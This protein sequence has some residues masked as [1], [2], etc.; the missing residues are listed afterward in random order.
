[1]GV[2]LTLESSGVLDHASGTL[3]H[4]GGGT[5]T[6]AILVGGN[7]TLAAQTFSMTG[8][9]L[10]GAGVLTVADGATADL[11]AG[12]LP[13]GRA[14]DGVAARGGGVRY[15]NDGLTRKTGSGLWQMTG[16]D[17]E[18][19]NSG[20]FD[21][22][23]GVL[24][25]ENGRVAST[26]VFSGVG[27]LR[28][29][30]TTLFENAGAVAPGPEGAVGVLAVSDG[31]PLGAEGQ[32]VIELGGLAPGDEHDQLAVLGE[33]VVDG[34]L[35]VRLVDGFVPALGDQF[36][37]VPYETRTGTFAACDG[38]DLGGGLSLVPEYT[39]SGL[40]LAVEDEDVNQPPMA[41]DDAAETDEGVP[42]LVDVLANDS[43][44]DGDPLQLTAVGSPKSGTAEAAE[45]QVL[46]TPAPGFSGTDRFMYEIGDGRGGTNTAQVTVTVNPEVNQPPQAN[47][48]AAETDEG[49]P[50]LIDVLANDSDPDGDPLQLTAVG[51]PENGTAEAV[52]GQVLYTPA[53]G[54]SGTDAFSYEIGD[55]RGGVGTAQVSVT[56][57]P[58][59]VV[60]VTV[61]DDVTV[62]GGA[63]VE[64][65]VAGFTPTT[66]E[67]RFRPGGATAYDAAPLTPEGEGYRAA[68]PAVTLRGIDYYVF[69]S[70][71]E[72]TV[73]VP[74]EDPENEPIH[75]QVA[76][77]IVTTPAPPPPDGTYR[78]VSVPVDLD[79]P[80]PAAAFEDDY[81]PYDPA[82]WRLLRWEP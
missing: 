18:I 30:A 14:A 42:V 21:V 58:R 17:F 43:D 15:V 26:G 9:S 70:D 65:F 32:L 51:A 62:G 49:V 78:M 82:D 64:V 57:N 60:E 19:E 23:E 56:V 71:G 38:C 8:F 50:V 68:I 16:T 22:A 28:V 40:V 67:V 77:G 46:Y 53:S 41:N 79:D 75:L 66:A 76:V 29:A 7:L 74:A 4:T 37:I 13:V 31:F 73:T 11:V 36:L 47:G 3:R 25:L 10:S 80:D 6:G 34:T 55:G 24:S 63:S 20:L 48:D 5:S 72:T 1:Q 2:G 69:L 35:A 39:P 52:D 27:E 12:P 54:F 45:G 33:A 59:T 81:G 61:E 44:P